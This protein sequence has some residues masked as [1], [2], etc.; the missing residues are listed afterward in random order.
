[1]STSRFSCFFTP[2]TILVVFA[3][4][5]VTAIA[6]DGTP[7]FRFMSW[8][9]GHFAVGKSYKS[10]ILEEDAEARG[11][12]YRKHLDD[13]GA[14]VVGICEYSDLFTTNGTVRASDAVFSRYPNKEIGPSHF[15]QWNAL[16]W[17]EYPLLE[18]RVVPY[19]EH[20]QHTYYVA[21]RL[22]IGG[23]DV[24]F[25]E[26][27]LDWDLT[28]EGHARD[29]L[30]QMEKLI[31]DFRDAP[32]VVMA[33]DF[34]VGTRDVDGQKLPKVI[35]APEEYDIF[36]RAGYALAN[37]DGSPTFPSSHPRHPLDN[38]IVKGLRVSDTRIH[39]SGD[40]SDHNAISCLLTM[41]TPEP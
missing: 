32:R 5:L 19:P 25:V 18:K 36:V 27:H 23:T 33:G 11:A 1:M 39:P 29:R 30:S 38:I 8:N 13:I 6:A 35:P 16:F 4:S 9:I 41:E 14:D 40:L 31:E 37:A 3:M 17:G 21:V 24:W 7:S 12:A 2:P 15:Y 34:N 22:D 10:T 28:S 26:T 20:V